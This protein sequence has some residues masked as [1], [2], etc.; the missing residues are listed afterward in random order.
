MNAT[1]AS[2]AGSLCNLLVREIDIRAGNAAMYFPEANV[3]IPRT[4]DSASRTP[5][6]KSVA[7]TISSA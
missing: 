7:I 4:L 5:A 2:A 3:L 6:F 1:V